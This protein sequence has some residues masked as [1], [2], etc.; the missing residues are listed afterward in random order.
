VKERLRDILSEIGE[1][2]DYLRSDVRGLSRYMM[3]LEELLEGY[4]TFAATLA[5]EHGWLFSHSLFICP[6]RKDVGH[7]QNADAPC[8]SNPYIMR[9][10]LS[11]Q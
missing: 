9:H 3:E 1:S 2:F 8:K 11:R 6:H 4:R 10:W 7:K 5:S